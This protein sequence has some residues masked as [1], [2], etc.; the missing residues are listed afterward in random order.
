MTARL[1]A[2]TCFQWRAAALSWI[3]AYS[4]SGHFGMLRRCATTYEPLRG[5]GIGS[6]LPPGH[7]TR[8]FAS[9]ACQCALKMLDLEQLRGQFV[10]LHCRVWCRAVW[11]RASIAQLLA[12][13]DDLLACEAAAVTP[14]VG[15]VFNR[16]REHPRAL[17]E[18]CHQ[19]GRL[20]DEACPAVV[21]PTFRPFVGPKPALRAQRA[22]VREGL[23]RWVAED[24]VESRG[25]T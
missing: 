23:A 20:S 4:A 21:G 14:H 9:A 13:A 19:S 25:R 5:L 2:Q 11:T 8:R 10:S 16:V 18:H 6:S 24:A 22:S 17:L 15:S 1:E 7:H 12:W 3:T